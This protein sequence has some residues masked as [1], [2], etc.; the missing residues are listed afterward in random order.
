MSLIIRY[1]YTI[2]R[3]SV[4]TT[5]KYAI[6]NIILSGNNLR[7]AVVIGV[8]LTFMNGPTMKSQ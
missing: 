4:C 2:E 3:R 8:R 1:D 5:N 7:T 6:E